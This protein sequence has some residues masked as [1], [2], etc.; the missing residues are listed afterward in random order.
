MYR[1]NRIDL[2]N[3]VT[4]ISVLYSY[5]HI[6]LLNTVTTISVK[7]ISKAGICSLLTIFAQNETRF[8][9]SLCAACTRH[10][11]IWDSNITLLCMK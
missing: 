6:D 11:L 3:T 5:Y 2:L 4:T 10:K 9:N 1:Y 7:L 8:N